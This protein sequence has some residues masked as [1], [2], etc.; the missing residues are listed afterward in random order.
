M[1]KKLII[2]LLF[3][4]FIACAD[5]KN[6]GYGSFVSQG[7]KKEVIDFASVYVNGK[8]KDPKKLLTKM[9]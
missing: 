5:N 4:L 3:P 2:L 7:V 8:L 1:K 9:A 6:A